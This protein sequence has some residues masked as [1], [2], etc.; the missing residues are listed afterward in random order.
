M[1]QDLVDTSDSDKNVEQ[2]QDKL[3]IS[4]QIILKRNFLLQQSDWTQLSDNQLSE[5]LKSNWKTYRQSLRDINKQENFP[6]I[7]FEEPPKI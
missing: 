2:L 5:Q 6:Y 3:E 1:I 7:E 4:K